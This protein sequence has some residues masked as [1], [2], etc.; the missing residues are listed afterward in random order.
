MILEGPRTRWIIGSLTRKHQAPVD[1]NVPAMVN[2]NVPEK[3]R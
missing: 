3:K 1:S 2:R